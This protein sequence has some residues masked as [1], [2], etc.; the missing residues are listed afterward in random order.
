MQVI[1]SNPTII[2]ASPDGS[3]PEKQLLCVQNLTVR[4]DLEGGAMTAVNDISFRITPGEV[5][6]LLGESGCGKTTTAL[7]LLRMLPETAETTGSITLNGRDLLRLKESQLREIRGAEVA[8]IY[9]DSSVLNPVIPAGTQVAEVLRAHQ[10]CTPAEAREKVNS[11]LAAIG[12][13]DTERIYNAYPHQLSGGQRQRIA[14][15][16]ALICNPRLVVADEPTSAVDNETAADIVSYIRRMRERSQTSFLFIS[17]DPDVLAT[18][19]DRVIVMYA[20]Q[21]VEDGPLADVYSQPMHPYTRALLDCA[22]GRAPLAE[23]AEV[24]RLRFIPGN[25]PAPHTIFPGCAFNDRCGDRMEICNRQKP[26]LFEASSARSAR[27][28]KC[29]VN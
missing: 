29:E 25:P 28:F 10:V 17:H 12:L 26:E 3:R 14:I 24:K 22:P 7:S 13:K 5:V 21:I 16:Q 4:Y 23:S 8:A 19:A 1:G 2:A 11:V 9:Q 15:A 27:C 6:G 20:G 18:I